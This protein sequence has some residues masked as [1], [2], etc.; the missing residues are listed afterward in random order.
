MMGIGIVDKVPMTLGLNCH[1]VSMVVAVLPC[2]TL[3]SLSQHCEVRMRILA[4]SLCAVSLGFILTP[5]QSANAE[6]TGGLLCEWREDD[7]FQ[8]DYAH[9]NI[10]TSP[11]PQG[12]N[13]WQVISYGTY[14]N[15]HSVWV[16][17]TIA[18]ESGDPHSLIDP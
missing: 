1:A 11:P 8:D 4:Q 10:C 16:Y 14:T 15:S 9:S 12:G 5:R 7:L 2:S 6:P 17:T 3:G 18:N 13:D